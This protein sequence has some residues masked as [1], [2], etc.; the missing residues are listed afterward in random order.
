LLTSPCTHR[1]G[2][3]DSRQI[4]TACVICETVKMGSLA[5]GL[6]MHKSF[7]NTSILI[8]LDLK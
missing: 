8:F 2:K 5:V 4:L 6:L 7:K 3:V 1:F